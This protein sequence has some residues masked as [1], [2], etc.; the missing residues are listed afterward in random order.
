MTFHSYKDKENR[1]KKPVIIFLRRQRE[2]AEKN[3]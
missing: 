2:Q 1:P 3:N